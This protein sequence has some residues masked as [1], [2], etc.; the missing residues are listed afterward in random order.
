MV[1][2][3]VGFQRPHMVYGGFLCFF[4]IVQRRTGSTDRFRHPLAAKNIEA[5]GTEKPP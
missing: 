5:F 1:T 2:D 3:M 4:N